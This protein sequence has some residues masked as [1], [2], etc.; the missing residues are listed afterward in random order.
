M[1]KLIT[2]NIPA[3]T[4]YRLTER[5]ESDLSAGWRIISVDVA[6]TGGNRVSETT[7]MVAVVL[8]KDERE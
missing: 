6:G 4:D 3:E 5:L 8:E 2:I 7:F 1:Q